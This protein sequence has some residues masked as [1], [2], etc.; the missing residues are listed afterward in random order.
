MNASYSG[1]PMREMPFSS[2][3]SGSVPARL[4]GLLGDQLACLVGR[5]RG[6]EELVH[7]AEVDRHREH[8]ALMRRVHLVLVAGE[9]RE[10]VDVLPDPLVGG[11]EEVRTVL[12]DLDARL[13]VDLRVGVAA[14][15]RAPID[16]GHLGAVLDG[17]SF[18]DGQTE[19][20]GTH[21]QEVRSRHRQ[22]FRSGQWSTGESQ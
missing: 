10:A 20:A 21:D 2:R 12:V 11:V 3:F 16:D 5:V 18:G 8:L 1:R 15:M 4:S 9:R 19:Q 7:G 13:L 6:A 14:D 17:G 22:S